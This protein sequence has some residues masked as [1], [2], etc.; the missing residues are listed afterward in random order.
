MISKEELPIIAFFV[1]KMLKPQILVPL[2][3]HDHGV[4]VVDQNLLANFQ[5]AQ[6]HDAHDVTESRIVNNLNN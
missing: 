2:G 5:V 6:G 3:R 1:P 4:V